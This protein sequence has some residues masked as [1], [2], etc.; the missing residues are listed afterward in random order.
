MQLQFACKF[1][2]NIGKR[3]FAG[4]GKKIRNRRHVPHEQN[5]ESQKETSTLSIIR[6]IREQKTNKTFLHLTIGKT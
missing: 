5:S 2:W 6:V 4:D 1:V 3:N